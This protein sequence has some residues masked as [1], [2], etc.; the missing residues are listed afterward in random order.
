MLIGVGRKMT[1]RQGR[2]GKKWVDKEAEPTQSQGTVVRVQ[3]ITGG[4]IGLAE[5]IEDVPW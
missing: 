2:M 1:L 5:D 4:L 3:P